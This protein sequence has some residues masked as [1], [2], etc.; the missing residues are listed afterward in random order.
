[1][2]VYYY[3]FMIKTLIYFAIHPK[4]VNEW[5]HNARIKA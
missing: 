5:K 2:S 1:M 3:L 4:N